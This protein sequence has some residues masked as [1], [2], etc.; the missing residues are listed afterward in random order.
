MAASQ[1]GGRSGRSPLAT[2]DAHRSLAD[3]RSSYGAAPLVSARERTGWSTVSA[4]PPR[5][6]GRAHWASRM[7]SIVAAVDPEQ[8]W[9]AARDTPRLRPR[10]DRHVEPVV[11]EEEVKYDAG[12]RPRLSLPSSR[13]RP[14]PAGPGTC[15]PFL[16]RQRPA[17]SAAET[18]NLGVVR[19]QDLDLSRPR[20]AAARRSISVADGLDLPRR[21]P[22][23][24]PHGRRRARCGRQRRS[25]SSAVRRGNQTVGTEG[26][27]GDGS[28]RSRIGYA[29]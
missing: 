13:R 10:P 18:V 17:R 23:G 29:W 14:A 12:R 26:T 2:L 3:D 25:A 24:C 19:R 6:T 22:A 11:R 1:V 8:P 7:W 15:R 4:R 5:R 16:P 9:R 21:S 28:V 20:P 27:P